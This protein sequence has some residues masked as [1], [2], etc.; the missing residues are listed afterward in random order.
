MNTTFPTTS[1]FSNHR[2]SRFQFT[3]SRLRNVSFHSC[4]RFPRKSLKIYASSNELETQA[5]EETKEELE[6][7]PKEGTKASTPPISA[8]LDKDLKKV[9]FL[10]FY[11]SGSTLNYYLNK[12]FLC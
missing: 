6:A 11:S 10:C 7:E 2:I 9:R 3:T 8:P 5:L 4:I 12:L 1:S